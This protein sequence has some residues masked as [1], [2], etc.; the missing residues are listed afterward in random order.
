MIGV[1][2]VTHGELAQAFIQ[3]AE[4]VVGEQRYVEAVSLSEKDD[5]EA[6][7]EELIQAIHRVN[8]GR[9]VI[10]LTDMFGGIA[11]NLAI[12]LLSLPKV[13]VIAGINLPMLVRIF[14]KRQELSLTECVEAAQRAGQK[15][16]HV[17]TQL[18]EPQRKAG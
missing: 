11:S 14:S 6:R 7:R 2:I 4:Q 1:V 15:Y 12:S 13:E 8:T 5:M 10:V 3:S 17:A 18:L 9:G 16:I